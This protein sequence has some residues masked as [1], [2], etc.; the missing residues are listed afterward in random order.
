MLENTLWHRASQLA[1]QTA[2]GIAGN[3][4][5]G[6]DPKIPEEIREELRRF[7]RWVEENFR[8]PVTL[9]VDFAYRHYLLSR[10]KERVGYLFYWADFPTRP[11][12]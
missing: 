1:I 8:L 4:D 9:W 5:I 7:V 12:F 10:R 11:V 2:P 3:F 6:F